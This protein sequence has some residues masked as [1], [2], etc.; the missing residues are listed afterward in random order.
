MPDSA[1][2]DVPGYDGS[3]GTERGV[4]VE[5][6]LRIDGMEGRSV[7][8]AY[9]LHDARN[10]LPFVSTTTPLKPDAP[11]W[12]RRGYVWLPVPAPGS[13]YVRVMLNDSTGRSN[14]GPRTPDFTIE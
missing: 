13:Y 6:T 5:V 4:A 2:L 12:S 9:T 8:F 3:F 14:D 1:R 10:D 7:P 11:R